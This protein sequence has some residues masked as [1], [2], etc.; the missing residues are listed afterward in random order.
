M[1]AEHGSY[2]KIICCLQEDNASSYLLRLHHLLGFV[3]WMCSHVLRLSSRFHRLNITQIQ[4]LS[5]IVHSCYP[6]KAYYHDRCDFFALESLAAF[7]AVWILN[8]KLSLWGVFVRSAVFWI[9][10]SLVRRPAFLWLLSYGSDW[11][12]V[13]PLVLRSHWKWSCLV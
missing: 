4:C 13:H 3:V 5:D 2:H 12:A 7:S 6:S 8:I 1:I 10:H 11:P 9:F